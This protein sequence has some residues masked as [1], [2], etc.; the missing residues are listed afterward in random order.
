MEDMTFGSWA[1]T[2]EGQDAHARIYRAY[3]R[4]G[5]LPEKAAMLSE[6]ALKLEYNFASYLYN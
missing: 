1:R 5:H 3:L 4:Q 2:Q 6:D